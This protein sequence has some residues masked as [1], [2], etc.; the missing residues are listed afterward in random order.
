M[1][2]AFLG[3]GTN[4]GDR[5][6]NLRAARTALA[7]IATIESVSSVWE[8]APLYVV[9][10]P[11][12]L[13]MAMAIVTDLAPQ[14]L[15]PRLKTLEDELGRVASIRFGPRLIDIDILFYDQVVLT[16]GDILI[17]PHPRLAERRFALAPLAEIA[18]SLLHPILG[19][20]VAVLL[21]KLPDDDDIHRIGAL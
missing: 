1:A 11:A 21:A 13:N 4:L 8:T 15:L 18:A 19:E 9:D 7:E 16:E 3:L 20:T 10:Q 12:F 14:D 5:L 17:L 2:L 6:G